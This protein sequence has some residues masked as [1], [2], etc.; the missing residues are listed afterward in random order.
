M[1]FAVPCFSQ[2]KTVWDGEVNPADC[3]MAYGSVISGADAYEGNA[4]FRAEPD[5]FHTSKIGFNCSNA[6][7]ANISGL[8]ELRFYIKSNQSGQTTSIRFTTYFAQSN[9]IDLGPYIQNG[10]GISLD[11]KEVRVPLNVF[12]KQGYDLSSIEYL[13][14]ATTTVNQLFFFGNI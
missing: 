14:F 9:W 6:W 12:K 3:N 4:C 8:D 1:A 11:Y 13:E 2:T 7:R 10:D 5:K